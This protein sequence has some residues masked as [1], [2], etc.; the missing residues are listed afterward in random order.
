MIFVDPYQDDDHRYFCR[1]HL[2]EKREGQIKAREQ[3]L[4]LPPGG[5]R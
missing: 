1:D 5:L 2:T 4:D 3:S